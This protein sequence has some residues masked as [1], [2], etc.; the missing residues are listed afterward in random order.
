M[1]NLN[2]SY[3]SCSSKKNRRAN[4]CTYT[5]PRI[6]KFRKTRKRYYVVDDKGDADDNDDKNA[7][8]EGGESESKGENDVEYV[9]VEKKQ[10][11]D[12]CG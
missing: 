12:S 1:V 8:D 11:K 3:N 7:D 2:K 5:L 6:E 10:K 9:K 4:I